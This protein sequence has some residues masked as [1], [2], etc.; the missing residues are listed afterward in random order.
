MLF[1]V[2]SAWKWSGA[3]AY[4]APKGAENWQ[5]KESARIR[6]CT[7][8]KGSWKIRMKGLPCSFRGSMEIE[9]EALLKELSTKTKEHPVPMP[10]WSNSTVPP[11]SAWSRKYYEA[12]SSRSD[13]YDLKFHLLLIRHY[14]Q[15]WIHP[16]HRIHNI[17]CLATSP[18][19]VITAWVLVVAQLECTI[20]HLLQQQANASLCH[21]P[22]S[23][24]PPP[25]NRGGVRVGRDG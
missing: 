13:W 8:P 17:L 25:G 12:H 18:T 5:G 14:S 6:M 11:V 19:G 3:I 24:P 23:P 22:V 21:I 10:Q 1:F 16:E 9:K 7:Q 15:Q 2:C 4:P 20:S